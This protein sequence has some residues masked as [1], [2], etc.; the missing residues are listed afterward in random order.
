VIWASYPAK[1]EHL[2]TLLQLTAC[3]PHEDQQLGSH[4]V[5]RI[6]APGHNLSRIYTISKEKISIADMDK[7]H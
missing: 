5:A 1:S 3:K 6:S 4:V 2:R 7:I